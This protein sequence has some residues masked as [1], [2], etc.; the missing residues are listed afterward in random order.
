MN[1]SCKECGGL[2]RPHVVW[3]HESL[4]L[5]VFE[6]IENEL[7]KCDLFVIVR[8]IYRVTFLLIHIFIVNLKIGTSGIVYPA[9]RFSMIVSERK[10]P[11]SEFN[12]DENP[13]SKNI[14]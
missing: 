8:T 3:F 9:A 5:K 10:V 1:L 4:D 7:E 2:I 11:I 6:K 13:P 14:K 12:I